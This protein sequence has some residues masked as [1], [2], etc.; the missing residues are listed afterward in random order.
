M[1]KREE[2]YHN[3]KEKNKDKIREKH[4]CEVCYGSYTY[5]HKSTH[6]KTKIHLKALEAKEKGKEEK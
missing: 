4:I 1:E 6:N 3:F 2:Y 5:F